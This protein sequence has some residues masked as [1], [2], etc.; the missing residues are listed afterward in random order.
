VKCIEKDCKYRTLNTGDD[1]RDYYFCE[2]VGID[3]NEGMEECLLDKWDSE[4]DT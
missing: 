1:T 4:S 2:Y 3:V